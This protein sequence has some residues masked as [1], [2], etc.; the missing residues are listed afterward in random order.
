VLFKALDALLGSSYS[1][2]DTHDIKLSGWCIYQKMNIVV[3]K[4]AVV[5]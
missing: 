1:H 5:R 2:F 4:L 3:A